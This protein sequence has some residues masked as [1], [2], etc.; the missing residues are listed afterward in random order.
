V[1]ARDVKI[2]NRE[3]LHMRPATEFVTIANRYASDVRVAVGDQDANGKSIFE[4]LE[5]AGVATCGA[6]LRIEADG[7]DAEACLEALARL[8]EEKFHED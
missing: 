2:A 8:V 3:G 7:D 1:A 5:L 6:V 4:L